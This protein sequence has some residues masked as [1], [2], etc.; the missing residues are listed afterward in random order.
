[1]H[2]LIGQKRL[3]S[4]LFD[5][6]GQ[7]CNMENVHSATRN[8]YSHWKTSFT[9]LIAIFIN[10]KFVSFCLCWLER[11]THLVCRFFYCIKKI[12]VKVTAGAPSLQMHFDVRN[13]QISTKESYRETGWLKKA[14][15]LLLEN[16]KIVDYATSHLKSIIN[17]GEPWWNTS[18][19]IFVASLPPLTLEMEGLLHL[20]S[21]VMFQ[22]SW[23]MIKKVRNHQF[24]TEE[25]YR[26]MG[27]LKITVHLLSQE[28]TK[29]ED[30]ATSQLKSDNK[31]NPDEIHL[32][33]SLSYSR[34]HSS[35]KVK[36]CCTSQLL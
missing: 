20:S 27:W 18:F 15:H 31:E 6:C 30:Y 25:W 19:S 33:A 13:H 16:T 23:C 3:F 28:N 21:F 12:T 14:V 35:L 9:E 22:H 26:E 24:S 36:V 5:I 34:H 10:S 8:I 1:M 29:I 32:S 7:N 17:E 11:F 2:G 4:R